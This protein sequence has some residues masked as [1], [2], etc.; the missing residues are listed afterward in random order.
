MAVCNTDIDD[1]NEI[2]D[3]NFDD[4]TT[5]IDND[6]T[7][8]PAEGH[9]K[10]TCNSQ[11]QPHDN[12]VAHVPAEGH[13]EVQS[14]RLQQRPNLDIALLPAEGHFE[15]QSDRLPQQQHNTVIAKQHDEGYLHVLSNRQENTAVHPVERH[16]QV[17]GCNITSQPILEGISKI[18]KLTV[19]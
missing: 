8:L 11:Q 6:V 10:V 5:Q 9:F 3:F 12:D 16:L 14:D 1:Q 13:F 19:Q 7:L 2:D 4:S 17:H 18:T 15:V